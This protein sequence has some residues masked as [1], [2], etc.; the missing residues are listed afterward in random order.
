MDQPRAAGS[1]GLALALESRASDRERR[2]EPVVRTPMER[3]FGQS[4]ADVVIHTDPWAGAVADRLG[5]SAFTVGRH[6]VF[7]P[8]EFDPGSVEGRMLVAHELAH[9]V[10][11]R[12]SGGAAG[13]PGVASSRATEADADQAAASAVLGGRST[14]ASSAAAGLALQG[15]QE[16]RGWRDTL[17][18]EAKEL[19]RHRAKEEIGGAEG[20]ALEV[21]NIVDTLAWL[22]YAKMDLVDSLVDKA[23]E[24]AKLSEGN[25]EALRFVGQASAQTDAFTL[26]RLRAGA[27][28]VGLTDKITGAPAISTGITTAFTWIE[29]LS[30]EYLF[31]GMASEQGWLTTRELA[32]VETAILAQVGLSYIGVEEVQLALKLV[33]LVG[34]AKGIV[35]AV[36]E[37][38]QSW[39]AEPKFWLAVAQA[40]LFMLG[41]GAASAGRKITG[42]V[43]DLGTNLLA[44][45]GE[46]LKLRSDW[47]NEHSPDREAVLHADITA[48]LKAVV[49]AV[50]QAITHARSLKGGGPRASVHEG[51]PSA[52]TTTPRQPAPAEPPPVQ[53]TP[54]A[55]HPAPLHPTEAGHQTPSPAAP[56]PTT[57]GGAPKPPVPAAAEVASE[58]ATKPP[59]TA[60]AKP[61]APPPET[62][63]KPTP[64]AAPTAPS[65]PAGPAKAAG[66]TQEQPPAATKTTQQAELAPEATPEEAT[67]AKTTTKE[68]PA[69]KPAAP[70]TESAGLTRAKKDLSSAEERRTE[71][72]A[73]HDKAV[74]EH[75]AAQQ[76]H[77]DAVKRLT[78]AKDALNSAQVRTEAAE[79][80]AQKAEAAWKQAAKGQ[81]KEPYDQAR[82][83]RKAAT[84]AADDLRRARRELESAKRTVD[85]AQDRLT[86]RAQRLDRAAEAV[87]VADERVIKAQQ[88]LQRARA[89]GASAPPPAVNKAELAAVKARAQELSSAAVTDPAAVDKLRALYESQPDWVLREMEKDPVA[90]AELKKRRADNPELEK[91]KASKRQPHT[92]TVRVTDDATGATVGDPDKLVSGGVT[93]EQAAELGL[94]QASLESHTEAKAVN[95]VPLKPGQ[96][97]RIT[98]Q[99]DPCGSCRSAMQA[100][101][102]ATGG[103][104]VYWWPGGPPGGIRYVPAIPTQGPGKA[105]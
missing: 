9:I 25:R 48:L 101:A 55:G 51:Q 47:M 5:A 72:R 40:V 16:Q 49:M 17:L 2:L 10:Q 15:K 56:R 92:A 27:A 71:A 69:P 93:P 52:R 99:Y 84:A 45:S 90:A 60:A 32:Q 82:A 67:A 85:K 20:L 104:I 77:G 35:A 24:A 23:A 98:G 29:N 78:A 73:R 6:I 13:G 89:K 91:A 53:H 19:I 31:A 1:A 68:A 58:P 37:Y 28:N 74:G 38:P 95:T 70:D 7:G 81:R 18:G 66:P 105:P 33:A 97:M 46:V 79:A 22:P 80:N 21:G 8:G 62:I 4:L 3:S 96:T 102:N 64:E 39:W 59:A 14:V 42:F 41:L 36:Q 34:S 54:P 87:G 11:Q 63:P 57:T 86:G 88:R 30:D 61:A 75:K 100:A 76:A 43:I 12:R 65:E 83:A 50:I 94:W 44:T 26:K 103:T